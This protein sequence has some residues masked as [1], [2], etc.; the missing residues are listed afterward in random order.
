MHFQGFI[1]S[2]F[3]D[4]LY[5]DSGNPKSE[6]EVGLITFFL[7]IIILILDVIKTIYQLIFN[8]LSQRKLKK[9]SKLE[10][11]IFIGGVL[12]GY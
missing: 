8:C 4:H 3:L 10:S 12:I 9:N 2:T 7:I 1:I 5:Y 11:Q 6:P